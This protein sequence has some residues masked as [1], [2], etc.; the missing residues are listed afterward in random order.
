[1]D[2]VSAD[3]ELRASIGDGADGVCVP[4]FLE[5]AF[6]HGVRCPPWLAT[7]G[8]A[9]HGDSECQSHMHF[10]RRK[11]FR[12]FAKSS[13]LHQETDDDSTQTEQC[14]HDGDDFQPVLRATGFR[15]VTLDPIIP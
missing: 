2:E 10:M 9:A 7:G 15:L 14:H 3:E 1:V 6:S 12:A 4:D 13:Q 5:E 11:N 8:K